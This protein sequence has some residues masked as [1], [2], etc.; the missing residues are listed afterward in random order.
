MPKKQ[1]NSKKTTLREQDPHLE[2]EKLKYDNPLPSREYVLTLLAEQGVPMYPAELAELL[3]IQKEE[4]RYFERRLVAMER[5]GQVVINRK[6]A[7]CVADKLDLIKCTVQGHRD[8]F[9]FAVPVEGGDDLFL[10]ERELH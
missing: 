5:D 10:S 6:G 3:S 2:R 1:N 9:G 7:V 8:G 4:F